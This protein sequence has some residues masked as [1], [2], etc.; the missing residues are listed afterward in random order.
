VAYDYR[1]QR[2][3][4][5]PAGAEVLAECEPIYEERPG[6]SEDIRGARTLS[7]LPQAALDYVQRIEEL[8]DAPAAFV[9]V[10]PGREETIV[11]HCG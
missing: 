1:G 8:A 7:D 11:V 5:F 9:S 4:S 2:L 10:G 3:E 6:W